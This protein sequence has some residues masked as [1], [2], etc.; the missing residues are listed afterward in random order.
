MRKP[1][2]PTWIRHLGYWTVYG[3]YFYLINILVNADF[4]ILSL[5]MILPYFM[6]VFYLVH[7]ILKRFFAVGKYLKGGAL[8]LLFYMLSGLV[9]YT[10]MH[11]GSN[12]SLYYGR[13]LV[14]GYDFDWKQFFQSLLVMHGHFSMLAVLYFHYE[15]KLSATQDRL[16]EME[17]RL[18]AEEE[19]QQY[20]YAA[21]AAQVNPHMMANIFLTWKQQLNEVSR[22]LTGQMEHAYELM[23]FY[24]K[25]Q[26]A[27]GATTI[28]LHDE[29]TAVQNYL[30]M[31]RGLLLEEFFVDMEQSGNML[32]FSV[33]PTSLLTLV[34]NAFKHGD[35]YQQEAPVRIVVQAEWDSYQ[36]VV[37]NA[38]RTDTDYAVSHGQ[39]LVNLERRLEMVFGARAHLDISDTPDAYR[40]LISIDCKP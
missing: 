28:L 5:M 34:D 18:L 11:G 14:E 2:L 1:N 23:L 24:M 8:L 31:Q 32:R 17:R 29:I 7:D 6:M 22:E 30:E 38:K 36:L 9:V 25:A 21:L 39:G 27:N 33:P 20:E 19:K 40:A 13:F 15:G 16:E 10:V 37:T 35:V 3:I 12:M 4:T 26:L